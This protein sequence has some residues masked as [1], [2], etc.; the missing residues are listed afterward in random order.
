[1]R[2][3]PTSVALDPAGRVIDV[4]RPLGYEVAAEHDYFPVSDARAF[5]MALDQA[6]LK[7]FKGMHHA[8]PLEAPRAFNAALRSFFDEKPKAASRKGAK[9]PRK[10]K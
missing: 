2:V 6:R 4:P 1:M 10:A 8:V 3:V 5:A 9:T 7:V